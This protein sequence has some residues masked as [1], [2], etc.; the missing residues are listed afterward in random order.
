MSKSQ[1]KKKVMN[2]R[3]DDFF[4]DPDSEFDENDA[5]DRIIVE[6]M[7]EIYENTLRKCR[8]EMRVA[9]CLNDDSMKQQIR[10]NAQRAMEAVGELDVILAELNG[11]DVT[12]VPED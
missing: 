6:Q 12:T 7:K 9:N 1:L 4:D 2:V 10:Q 3:L 11:E 8:L 5:I